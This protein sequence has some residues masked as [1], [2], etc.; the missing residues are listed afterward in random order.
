MKIRDYEVTKSRMFLAF[1]AFVASCF[2]V[3]TTTAHAVPSHGITPF[4]E[5]KYPA[6]FSHFDYVNPNAPKGGI[7][8]QAFTGSFDSL[9]PFILKGVVAPGMNMVFETLMAPSFDEPQSYYGLIAQ[10]IEVAPDRSYADFTLN[11]AAHWH[12][13]TPITA[14]DVVFSLK[15]FKTK[16]HPSFRILYKPITKAKALGS[17]K[18]RFY[19]ADT[20]NREL[21]ILAASMFVLPKHY[22]ATHRFDETTLTPPLGSGPYK[23]S[24]VD[25]GR[26]IEFERVKNY[27]AR[28]VNVTRGL[29]NFDRLRFDVY[30]DETVSVEAMKSKQY[31]VR[32]EYIARNWATA[33]N[34]PA[35]KTGELIQIKIPNKVPRGMQ[36]FLFNL[37]QS[38][39]ADDR[40]REAISLAM[41]YEWMNEKLFWSAYTRSYSFF[42]S[43]DFMAD[44]LPEKDELALLAPYKDQL[45][46]RVFTDI[47]RPSVTDGSGHDRAPLLK[48]QALLDEAGWAL[49]DGKRVN[50]K[51]GEPLAIEFLMNQ[52]TF[53]RVIASFSKNLNRLGIASSFRFVDDSQY[54]KRI[55][56]RDFDIVSIWWNLGIHFP[57]NEQIGFWH[58]NQADVKG[59]NNL[60][61]L[62]HKVVDALLTKLVQSQTMKELKPAA[63]ALDRVLLWNHVVIPHWHLPAWRLLYWNRL[64]HPNITPAYSL[65]LESWWE[66]EPLK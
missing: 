17:Y 19:F 38:K 54:Q 60:S 13:G 43:T 29:Y 33:F 66:K 15:T 18:V 48:A 3:F 12:D 47:Y 53:Q 51:T 4:G 28:H 50:V 49:V 27:W 20:T 7:L 25:Q 5:L 39:F 8:R 11:K 26:R 56:D 2:L 58:S 45:P 16:A 57:G 21:P 62:K 30:R 22:Y 37:R 52:R 65:G 6:G 10:S 14:D 1:R 44:H 61:G 59:G 42:Q 63:R 24:K 31:D 41:D 36:A 32:E 64:G 34:I 23:V 40:V 46:P 55:D 35:L 9:N